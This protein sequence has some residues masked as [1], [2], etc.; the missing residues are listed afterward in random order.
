MIRN[1]F[2][3][4]FCTVFI[5]SCEQSTSTQADSGQIYGSWQWIKT[6]GGFGPGLKT[7]QS[8]GYTAKAVF[9]LEGIA[10]YFRN[11]TIINQYQFSIIKDT[12]YS[13][14]S[15]LLHLL[16]TESYLDQLINF[17]G[18]DSLVLSDNASDA[19]YNFYVRIRQ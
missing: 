17:H 11:D 16:G 3:C 14:I 4:L 13:H 10:Q 18:S 7:P 1:I 2:L 9:K 15:Y 19:F 12:S 5:V 8:E 6:T